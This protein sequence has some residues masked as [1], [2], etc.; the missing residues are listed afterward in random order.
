MFKVGKASIAITQEDI[1]PATI[2]SGKEVSSQI[3]AELK[4]RT[5]ALREKGH[6]PGLAVVLQPAHRQGAAIAE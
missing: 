2:I 1:M 4:V 5:A 6:V 3:R